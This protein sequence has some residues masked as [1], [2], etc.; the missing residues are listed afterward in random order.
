MRENLFINYNG[1]IYPAS[2]PVFPLNRAMSY[3][4]GLFE[5]IRIHNGEILFFEDHIDRL[6][7]GMKALKM[8]VPEYFSNFFFHKQL[9][10]LAQKER[11][12]G[13][14]RVR[15]S[16]FR[17]GGGLYHPLL[18]QPEYFLQVIPLQHGYEWSA[19]DCELGIFRDVPKDYSAISF[20]KSINA[21]PYVMAAIFRQENQLGECI[22]LNSFGKITDAV[23]SNI[24]WTAKDIFYTTPVADGGVEG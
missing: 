23:S 17:S 9:V 14:A 7:A 8:E 10:D 11:I 21:L 1:S 3:G 4:D 24:F 5:S 19:E 16:V 12:A 22:L 18:Q 2:D 15:L 20:F 13:N 6:F